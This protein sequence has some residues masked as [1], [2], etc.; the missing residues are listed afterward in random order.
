MACAM[1]AELG[2]GRSCPDHIPLDATQLEGTFPLRGGVAAYVR[3]IQ[4]DDTGRLRM[5]HRQLSPESITF[6]L[7][8]VLYAPRCAHLRATPSRTSRVWSGIGISD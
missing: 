3:A 4:S 6:R 8:P 2:G 7:H 5:F 1:A